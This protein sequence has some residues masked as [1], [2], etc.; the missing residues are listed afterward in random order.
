MLLLLLRSTCHRVGPEVVEKALEGAPERNARDL[1]VASGCRLA[2]GPR[3]RGQMQTPPT[4]SGGGQ[5][6]CVL[7]PSLSKSASHSAS[8]QQRVGGSV[9]SSVYLC[10]WYALSCHVM[11]CR[12]RLAGV[13]LPDVNVN[14]NVTSA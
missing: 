6:R 8:R 1:R 14:V 12:R 2:R 3:T 13:P 5:G 7:T 10:S 4:R 9:G 11:P